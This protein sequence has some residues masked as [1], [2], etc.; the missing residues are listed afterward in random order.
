MQGAYPSHLLNYGLEI[1][2]R[3]KHERVHAHLG[4]YVR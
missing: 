1:F 4:L 3:A 2:S